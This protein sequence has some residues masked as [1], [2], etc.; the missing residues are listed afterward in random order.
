MHPIFALFDL[1]HFC[2]KNKMIHNSTRVC[3]EK[4]ANV[5]CFPRHY[6]RNWKIII[7]HIMQK[8]LVG[9]SV[10]IFFH[11]RFRNTTLL[12][13][14]SN[15]LGRWHDFNLDLLMVSE[16]MILQYH[17]DLI[18]VFRQQIVRLV[19]CCFCSQGFH[20]LAKKN[21]PKSS[22]PWAL[23]SLRLFRMSQKEVRRRRR[24]SVRKS[25]ALGKFLKKNMSHLFRMEYEIVTSSHHIIIIQNIASRG[26]KL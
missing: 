11:I 4:I 15:K 14:L 6:G 20:D 26:I 16:Q 17:S 19:R 5:P 3:S 18:Q 22:R 13:K 1:Y 24:R 7:L 12:S 9:N 25:S 10:Q 23:N 21:L 8:I 2:S